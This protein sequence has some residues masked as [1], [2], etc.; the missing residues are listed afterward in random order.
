MNDQIQ[1]VDF[2]LIVNLERLGIYS[3]QCSAYSQIADGFLL[4][5]RKRS[6]SVLH[7]VVI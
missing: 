2:S 6:G 3:W 5:S 1:V 7:H 4:N